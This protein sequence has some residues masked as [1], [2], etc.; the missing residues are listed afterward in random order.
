[1]SG[2][3]K[4]GMVVS[5][6][7][8]I[9]ETMASQT[10]VFITAL[11]DANII[12]RNDEKVLKAIDALNQIQKAIPLAPAIMDELVK[13][14]P[15]DIKKLGDLNGDGNIDV[16]DLILTLQSGQNVLKKFIASGFFDATEAVNWQDAFSKLI[17]ALNAKPGVHKTTYKAALAQTQQ[18]PPSEPVPE[19]HEEVIRQNA[20][21]RQ[22][23]DV[24][25]AELQEL[26]TTHKTMV[27]TNAQLVDAQ[28][29]GNALPPAPESRRRAPPVDVSRHRFHTHT[30]GNA[31]ISFNPQYTGDDVS[32]R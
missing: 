15:K 13:I 10:Q 20:R 29:Q 8:S 25:V 16:K 31:T 32:F 27:R 28:L 23:R 18:S 5:E 1:M 6:V 30:H 21:L 12:N 22:Q 3:T 4:A 24:A 7:A 2:F 14:V 9:L 19:T 26:R 11:A 17:S